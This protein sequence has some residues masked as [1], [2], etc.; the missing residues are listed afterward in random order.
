MPDGP[1]ALRDGSTMLVG[2]Y[3]HAHAWQSG[4]FREL[5]SLDEIAIVNGPGSAYEL[6][7]FRVW[8]GGDVAEGALCAAT[9]I[10]P[11]RGCLLAVAA[12]S[13]GTC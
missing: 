1:V 4:L 6:D 12:S 2:N 3:M 9:R 8:F 11:R 10:H 7:G 13:P 5:D